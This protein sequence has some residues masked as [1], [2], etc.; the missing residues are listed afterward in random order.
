VT[1]KE[2]IITSKRGEDSK[3]AYIQIIRWNNI[4]ENKRGFC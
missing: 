4:W 2:W 3:P 1:E